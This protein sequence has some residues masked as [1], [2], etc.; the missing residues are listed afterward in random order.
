MRTNRV[1]PCALILVLVG[2]AIVGCSRGPSEEELKYAELQQQFAAIQQQYDALTQMRADHAAH[3]AT[4][5]EIE[6][7]DERK[8]SDEQK[9]MLEEATLQLQELNASQEA[10]YENLQG[11]LA[12]FLNTGLNEFP[13]AEE[14]RA[15]LDIYAEEAILVARDMVEKAGDYKKATDHVANASML[16]EQAGMA[17]YAPLLEEIRSFEEWRFI[18]QERFDAVEKNMTMD[19]VK[20]VAGVPYYQNIQVD[21]KRGVETWLYRKA[22]GGAAAIYFKIK[23]GKVY[24]KNFDAVKPKVVE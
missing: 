11:A 9:A 1:L 19:Q 3:E 2:G 23:T 24:N 18:T 7:I 16:Y 8:R 4:I 17:V 15:A 20:E 6:A 5:A 10:E 21:E 12:E 22:E 13:D 14:T